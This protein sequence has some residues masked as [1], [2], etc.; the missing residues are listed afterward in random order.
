MYRS[1]HHPESGILQPTVVALAEFWQEETFSILQ[2]LDAW[3]R[4]M[5]EENCSRKGQDSPEG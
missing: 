5:A 1:V 4:F 3:K 2:Q